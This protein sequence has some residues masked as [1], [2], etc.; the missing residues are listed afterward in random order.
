MRP[1]S[2]LCVLL[3]VACGTPRSANQI[4]S[5]A[6]TTDGLAAADAASDVAANDAAVSDAIPDATPDAMPDAP[7]P[8]IP[9]DYECD[10]MQAG[11]VTV[12]TAGANT[13]LLIHNV[14]GVLVA[15]TT[16]GPTGLVA[17]TVP[18]CGAVTAVTSH[19]FHTVTYVRGGDELWIDSTPHTPQPQQGPAR[20]YIDVPPPDTT[21][22]WVLGPVAAPMVANDPA[23]RDLYWSALDLD[24]QG[25]TT[26]AVHRTDPITG[27][28][29]LAP[30]HVFEDVSLTDAIQSPLHVT[31]WSTL[32]STFQLQLQFG[33]AVE[34]YD[35][36]SKNW[37]SGES[38]WGQS[39]V[40]ASGTGTY[41][42]V[43]EVPA[44]GGGL[45]FRTAF[46]LTPNG[47]IRSHV[48]VMQWPQGPLMLDLSQALLPE[49]LA[50]NVVASSTR[51]TVSWTFA[52]GAYVKPDLAVLRMRGAIEWR[53][54]LPPGMTS[55][56]LP[57]LPSDLAVDLSSATFALGL[58]EASDYAGY[59]EARGRFIETFIGPRKL[60]M[61][62]T[63]RS[64]AFGNG[65]L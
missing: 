10:V 37:A 43:S 26:F 38:F 3:T 51:P 50:M 14:F 15:R 4:D 62:V 63:L 28:P 5:G 20:L 18:G 33:Q 32:T 13:P 48:Q 21:H 23:V 7:P 44:Y 42:I 46:R 2:L 11:T 55:F 57:E 35:T 30:Y 9:P 17:L 29:S 25:R 47:N 61:G 19:L 45:T 54:A 41:D 64:A 49:V 12:H 56:Q 31:T 39:S 24:A 40:T 52:S 34:L 60:P 27:Y 8:V 53:F 6:A 65:A 59:A 36:Q 58:H 16:S 22:Y 1:P